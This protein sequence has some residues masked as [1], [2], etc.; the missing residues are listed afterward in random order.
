M[1]VGKVGWVILP[2]VVYIVDEHEIEKTGWVILPVVVHVADEH[3]VEGV[4]VSTEDSK[5]IQ[6]EKLSFLSVSFNVSLQQL[7]LCHHLGLEHS[8]NTFIT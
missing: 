2:V 1:C 7:L 4:Q 3:W 6:D 5:L 8:N